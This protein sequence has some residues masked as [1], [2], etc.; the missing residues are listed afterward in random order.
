MALAVGSGNLTVSGLESGNEASVCASWGGDPADGS[1]VPP[2]PAVLVEVARYET[3]WRNARAAQPKL[4]A[5]Y[6]S[7]RKKSKLPPKKTE[8]DTGAA[9]KLEKK[10]AISIEKAGALTSGDH[11]WVEIQRVN[12]NRGPGKPGNQVDLP[13][14]SRV[15]FGRTPLRRKPNSSL[16]SVRIRYAGKTIV[17]PIRF[18]DNHMDK[19]TLPIPGAGGPPKYSHE[20]LL[21]S[22]RLDG[23]FDLT[24]GSPAQIAKWH[25]ASQKGGTAYEMR[26]GNAAVARK[27]GV[28]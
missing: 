3:M 7:K 11:F 9:K 13:H 1:F 6:A 12:E 8:D 17:R 24:V 28:F 15:F 25:T 27:W 10:Y 18:G 14:G 23:T 2:P 21:F 26:K 22:R 16:G 5:E 19:L 4:I 20:T